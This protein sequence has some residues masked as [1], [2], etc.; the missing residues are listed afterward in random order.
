MKTVFIPSRDEMTRRWRKCMDRSVIIC[1]HKVHIMICQGDPV[2]ANEMLGTCKA[3]R[4]CEN[5]I[6]F[7]LKSGEKR[8][9]RRRRSNV[10]IISKR[11]SKE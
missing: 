8:R 2:K 10:R 5:W 6:R 11:F 1:H 7:N 9:L 3:H 4:G